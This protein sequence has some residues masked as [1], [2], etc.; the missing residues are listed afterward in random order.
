M[1]AC[2]YRALAIFKYNLQSSSFVLVLKFLPNLG[3]YSRHL[4]PAILHKTESF[5]KILQ[6]LDSSF[7]K[8]LS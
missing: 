5:N 4:D 2:L 7:S 1:A 6:Q 8:I 3:A